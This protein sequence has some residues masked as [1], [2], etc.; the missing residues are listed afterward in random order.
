LKISHVTPSDFAKI[1]ICV[2][3][4]RD[5]NVNSNLG[6]GTQH[7]WNVKL[8]ANPEKPRIAIIGLALSG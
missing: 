5:S 8:S 4:K 3:I 7:S 6:Y 2:V 1:K